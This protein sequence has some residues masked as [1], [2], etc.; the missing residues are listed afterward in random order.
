MKSNPALEHVL[1]KLLASPRETTTIE[2]KSNLDNPREIGEYLS[3]LANTA[4]LEGHDR[5]WMLMKRNDLTLRHVLLLDRVQKKRPISS[6]DGRQLKL[7]KL[8]EGRAP[9]YYVSASVADWTGQKATYIHHRGL[10]DKH[11]QERIVQYLKKYGQATRRDIDDL[12]LPKLPEA[13]DAVQKSNKIKNLL[14][15]MR[16]Q[17]LIAPSGPRSTAVWHLAKIDAAGSPPG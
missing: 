5:A 15:T 6:E 14:Q 10:D 13:L 9:N 16:R 3:A 1:A 2:F 7:Q 11:Y 12:L 4:A 8:I 17:K